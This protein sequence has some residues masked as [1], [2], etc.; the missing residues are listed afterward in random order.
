MPDTIRDKAL[1]FEA[2][3]NNIKR[4]KARMNWYIELEIQG[5]D[6]PPDLALAVPGTRF[7]MAAVMLG[8]ETDEIEMPPEKARMKKAL[9]SAGL[10]C[11]NKDFQTWMVS[12]NYAIGLDERVVAAAV[13]RICDIKSR[14]EIGE[15]SD[16]ADA[17]ISLRSEFQMEL[18]T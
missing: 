1:Q 3:V 18:N 16:A 14:S 7:M 8:R 10:L 13:C 11:R 12:K 2:L 17:F 9:A 6:M 15:S 5:A 4:S